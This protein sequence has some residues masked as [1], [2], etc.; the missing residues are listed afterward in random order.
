MAITVR[1]AMIIQSWPDTEGP[2]ND[3]ILVSATKTTD[4]TLWMGDIQLVKN[5]W[6]HCTLI[7]TQPVFPSEEAALVEVRNVVAE[8]RALKLDLPDMGHTQGAT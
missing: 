5:G 3:G 7:S 8:V 4:K 6:Y 1:T 2:P